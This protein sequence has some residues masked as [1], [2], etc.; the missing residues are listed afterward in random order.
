MKVKVKV[1]VKV[2]KKK[3][4]TFAIRLQIVGYVLGDFSVFEFDGNISIRK[5]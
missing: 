3:N 5:R 2:K 1:K 4:G